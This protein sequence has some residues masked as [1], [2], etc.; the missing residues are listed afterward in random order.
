VQILTHLKLSSYLDLQE[1]ELRNAV[2]HVLPEAPASPTQGQVYYN[3]VTKV[4]NVYNGTTWEPVG[5]ID[6]IEVTG[7]IQKSTSGGTVTISIS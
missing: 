3:S 1:N 7:P 5:S 4:V 6:G 2:I